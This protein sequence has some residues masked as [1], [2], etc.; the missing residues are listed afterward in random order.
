MVARWWCRYAKDF[1]PT[2]SEVLKW[3]VQ[4]LSPEK[5]SALNEMIALE[6]EGDDETNEISVVY[7]D[8]DWSVNSK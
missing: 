2:T 7:L 3:I 5:A 4:Y 8:Y 6:S 1:G